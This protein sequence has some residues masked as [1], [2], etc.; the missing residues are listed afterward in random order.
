MTRF[1]TLLFLIG[2]SWI[3]VAQTN[4][5]VKQWDYSYGGY[6]GD[7][8]GQLLPTPDGGFIAAGMS[9]SNAM[10]E[11]SDDN[12][13]SAPFPSYD[14]W[15]I[16]CDSNGI[17][18]WDRTLGGSSDDFFYRIINTADSGY[19]M[20]ANSRSPA[21]GDIAEVPH[22]IFDVWAVKL[23]SAGVTEW[24]KRYGGTSVNGGTSAVPL[25]GGGFMIGG[26]TDSP[27]SGDVSEDSYGSYDFWVLRID[28]VG[29]IIWDKRY[30]GNDIETISRI[31]RT[32]DGGFLLAG[33]SGSGISG[34]KTQDNYVNGQYDMWFVKIDSSG[35]FIWDKIIG[36]LDNDTRMDI[37]QTSDQ[38]YFIASSTGAG[39]GGDKTEPSYGISGVTDFWV[40]R[41]DTALNILWD[42]GVGGSGHEDDFG[43]VFETDEG[44][45]MLAGTS[46]SDT[47]MWK[48]QQNNGPE[49]TWIVLIDTNGNKVWDKTVFT[50]YTH[51]EMGFGI[52]LSDGCYLFANDGDG[53]VADEKT[54]MSY[55]FDYWC[56]KFCDTA[57]QQPNVSPS[58]AASATEICEKFCISFYDS[59]ANAPTAWQWFF[60]GGTPAF[61]TLQDPGSICYNSPGIYDVTLV[62]TNANGNDTLTLPNYITVNATPPVPAIDQNGYLLA[63]SIAFA[64]QWQLNNVDIPGATNQLYEIQQTGYYTVVTSNAQGCVSSATVYVVITGETQPASHRDLLL[65]PN[66]SYGIIN[67][68]LNNIYSD[69]VNLNIF[70]SMGRVIYNSSF[71]NAAA[72]FNIQIDISSEPEG[73][74]FIMA[75]VSGMTYCN[76][77]LIDR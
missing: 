38:H 14:C 26:Y 68:V 35:N 12:W 59:S 77:F 27:I 40:M 7:F 15:I 25:A 60:P 11:K 17:K 72:S 76:Y 44:N 28:N 57:M 8:L 30:G 16:K 55:S 24:E 67:L 74:Y 10:F 41:T 4:S 33:S 62:T 54:D 36:S 29:N 42:H 48:S 21:S 63:S 19:L 66:P 23:N 47:N 69:D 5:L 1:Y 43:N 70:N 45:Y 73:I 53:M 6:E 32:E 2:Y 56:I 13:D 3:S 75:E 31:F 20:L 65:Y 58:F 22:G 34:L 51:T 52:Q 49:N 71:K 64:Y 37:V 50:G 18:Q 46:Y 9:L 39:I 61:S